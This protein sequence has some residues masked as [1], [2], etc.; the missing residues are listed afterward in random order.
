M[1][2]Y[3]DPETSDLPR[4]TSRVLLTILE[5]ESEQRYRP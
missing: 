3:G 5:Q 2:W 4:Y 1:D